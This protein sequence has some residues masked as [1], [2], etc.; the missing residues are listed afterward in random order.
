M[1]PL[2]VVATKARFGVIDHVRVLYCQMI[3]LEAARPFEGERVGVAL[4]DHDQRGSLGGGV[5]GT[6]TRT[7]ARI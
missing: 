2:D 6:L 4:G 7:E 5:A 1:V 3:A